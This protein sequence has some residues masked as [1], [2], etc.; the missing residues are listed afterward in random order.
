MKDAR[1]LRWYE[2]RILKSLSENCGETAM[3]VGLYVWGGST[4]IQAAST[5]T[6][7][8]KKL[9]SIG[10]VRRMDSDR[11]IIWMRTP[12]GTEAFE[13][14]IKPPHPHRR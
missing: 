4:P 5:A 12:A 11:P 6:P 3:V 8:L 2:V 9:E 10:L 13:S 14:S 7:A 1:T